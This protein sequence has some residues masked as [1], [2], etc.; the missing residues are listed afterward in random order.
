MCIMKSRKAANL[1]AN[2]V[3]T[4]RPYVWQRSLTAGRMRYPPIVADREK[5]EENLSIFAMNAREKQNNKRISVHWTCLCLLGDY[6]KLENFSMFNHNSHRWWMKFYIC[7]GSTALKSNYVQTKGFSDP[8]WSRVWSGCKRIFV[9]RRCRAA[10]KI[11]LAERASKSESSCQ[12]SA[13]GGKQTSGVIMILLLS[14]WIF[15]FSAK[16]RALTNPISPSIIKLTLIVLPFLIFC[17]TFN[18]SR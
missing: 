11:N 2:E 8:I 14:R 1:H 3:V 16:R 12:R 13:R 15:E 6:Y 10:N 4:R 18:E 9:F 5:S 7:T 17:W